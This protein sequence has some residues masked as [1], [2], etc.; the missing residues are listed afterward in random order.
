M[1]PFFNQLSES[2][3]K[4]LKEAVPLIAIYVAGADGSIEADEVNWAKKVTEIR[5]YKMSDDLLEFYQE[6]DAAFIE[7]MNAFLASFPKDASERNKLIE[8]KL[9]GLNTPLA[10]L[11]NKV[12]AHLYKSLT[13]FA[14]HVAKS[15]GGF[16]GFFSISNRERSLLGLKMINP[17]FLEDEDVNEEE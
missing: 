10:K 16:F 11:D 2:E 9:A 6:V 12:G 15:T 8:E 14:T 13:S 4:K 7:N 5:S 1:T 17:I 3:F